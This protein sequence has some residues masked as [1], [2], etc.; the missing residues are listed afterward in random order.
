MNNWFNQSL[1]ATALVTPC[2]LAIAFFDRNFGVKPNIF[3]IWYFAGIALSTALWTVI[4]KTNGIS[5]LIPSNLAVISVIL[6]G[7][8]LGTVANLLLF[9]AITTAPNPSFPS[10]I[11]NGGGGALV[12][13]FAVILGEIAPRYFGKSDINWMPTVIGLTLVISGTWVLAYSKK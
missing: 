12:F 9:T 1:I 4:T 2:W 6:V 13:V 10:V 8:T 3:I 7:M 5:Q 11:A